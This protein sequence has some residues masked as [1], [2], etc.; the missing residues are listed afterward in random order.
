MLRKY[1]PIYSKAVLTEDL[2]EFGL[3][4]GDIV[5]IMEVIREGSVP[6][7]YVVKALNALDETLVIFPA[8]GSQLRNL[9]R[10]EILHV[11][12]I[13]PPA[14]AEPVKNYIST[15]KPSVHKP[16]KKNRKTKY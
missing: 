1:T 13:Q 12:P 10:N 15:P 4:K 16:R 7:E 9:H 8:S 5:I 11:R 2:P 6:D 3:L 14:I